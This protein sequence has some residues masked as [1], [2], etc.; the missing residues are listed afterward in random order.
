MRT[1]ILFTAL[2]AVAAFAFVGC[3]EKKEPGE[4]TAPVPATPQEPTTT[5]TPAPGTT[6]TTPMV[7]PST[8]ESTEGA[9]AAPGTVPSA[10]GAVGAGLNAARDQFV[11]T[12]QTQLD[13]LAAK[14]KD[15]E[16]LPAPPNQSQADWAQLKANLE[17]K[18]ATARTQL[19]AA[20]TASPGDWDDM[21][22]KVT[23]AIEDAQDAYKDA[24]GKI[25]VTVGSTATIQTT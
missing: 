24:I 9:M 25:S 15:F 5:G 21:K 22:K 11:A 16:T 1:V 12:A 6:A 4:G 17:G 13:N 10:V 14:V 19:Q 7:P 23:S 8:M 2:L 18:L 3:G 20:S